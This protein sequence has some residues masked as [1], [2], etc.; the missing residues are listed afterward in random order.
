VAVHSEAEEVTLY[1][2]FDKKGGSSNINLHRSY[3]L[4]LLINTPPRHTENQ[5]AAHT[6]HEHQEVEEALYAVDDAK[7]SDPDLDE[8]AF[9]LACRSQTA[10]EGESF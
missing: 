1:D 3:Q 2:W 9:D 5:T 4:L 10:Q 6:R 8:S 7:M